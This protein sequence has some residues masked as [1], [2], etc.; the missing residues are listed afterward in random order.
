MLW[1]ELNSRVGLFGESQT[2]SVWFG[3]IRANRADEGDFAAF[4]GASHG[5][6]LGQEFFFS[7]FFLLHYL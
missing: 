6:L 4:L 1:R 7:F 3:V 5:L 2:R